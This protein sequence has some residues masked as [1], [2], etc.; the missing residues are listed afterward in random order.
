MR[1]LTGGYGV[2]T[3]SRG[4]VTKLEF[5][6]SGRGNGLTGSIPPELAALTDLES[7]YLESHSW[8][9]PSPALTG[10]IPTEL[11]RLE[12]LEELSLRANRLTG[13]IPTELARLPNLEVLVLGGNELAG[14]VPAEL[15]HRPISRFS[16][17]RATS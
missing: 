5:G 2:D 13:V 16:L 8:L 3:N 17:S 1:R 10:E 14:V 9:Q 6:R 12:N 7:L 15:G 11:A 4:R